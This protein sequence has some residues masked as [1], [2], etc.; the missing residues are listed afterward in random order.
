MSEEMKVDRGVFLKRIIPSYEGHDIALWVVYELKY[1]QRFG[2]RGVG[3][4]WGRF[5]RCFVRFRWSWWRFGGVLGFFGVFNCY[6]V[7]LE[8]GGGGIFGGVVAF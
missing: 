5:K 6:S 3:S 2:G 8:G 7:C 1:E 4:F